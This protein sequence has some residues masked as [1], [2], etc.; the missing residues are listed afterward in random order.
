MSKQTIGRTLLLSLVVAAV[1]PASVIGDRIANPHYVGKGRFDRNMA[2]EFRIYEK[3]QRKLVKFQAI[4]V[5]FLC[6]DGTTERLTSVLVRASLD[7]DGRGFEEVIY[8]NSSGE[9]WLWFGGKLFDNGRT[10]RG[11]VLSTYNP[12]EPPDGGGPPECTT[13]GKR[14]WI[15]KRVH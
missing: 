5:K 14:H 13:F 4:D 12:E 7:E 1:I 2:V 9:S 10:A 8:D 3:D 15:A 11:F 6:D